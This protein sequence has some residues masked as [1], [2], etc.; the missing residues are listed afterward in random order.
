MKAQVITQFEALLDGT[1][2]WIL[3]SLKLSDWTKKLDWPLNLQITRSHFHKSAE[4]SDELKAIVRE[5]KIEMH[6]KSDAG[7]LLIAGNDHLPARWIA[8]V[9]ADDWDSWIKSAVKVWQGLEKPK[10]RVFLPNF[11]KLEKIKSD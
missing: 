6:V 5:N 9:E 7:P 4:I 1:D 2:L 10:M 11:A 8:V 3:P